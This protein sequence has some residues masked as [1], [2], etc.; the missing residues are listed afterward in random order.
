MALTREQRKE[1]ANTKPCPQCGGLMHRQ[2]KRCRQCY[3]RE[4]AKESVFVICQGCGMFFPAA[5]AQ[6]RAGYGKYCSHFCRATY[7]NPNADSDEWQDVICPTCE[8]FFRKRKCEVRKTKGGKHFCSPECWYAY[9]TGSQHCLWGGGQNGRV[10]LEY[11]QWRSAVLERDFDRC[12]RCGSLEHLHAHHIIPWRDDEWERYEVANGITL[13]RS[14]HALIEQNP[15][16]WAENLRLLITVYH[17][18][19]Q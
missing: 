8:Q 4:R 13:C 5:I 1:R 3:N 11:R 9:N 19:G 17:P 16:G 15:Y 18:R 12:Q 7:N 2:S 14:C 6:L 10:S